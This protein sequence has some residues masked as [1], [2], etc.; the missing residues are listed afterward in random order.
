MA[1]AVGNTECP[2]LGLRMIS[3]DVVIEEEHLEKWR[4][5]SPQASDFPAPLR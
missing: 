1:F 5:R 4:D 2:V 3:D